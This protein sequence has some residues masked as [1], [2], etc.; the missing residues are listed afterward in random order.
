MSNKIVVS[1]PPVVEKPNLVDSQTFQRS[2]SSFVPLT[3]VLNPPVFMT[4]AWIMMRPMDHASLFGVFVFTLDAD[5]VALVRGDSFGEIDVVREQ[6]GVTR[7][8][9]ENHLLV[10]TADGVVRQVLFD[11]GTDLNEKIGLTIFERLEDRL[12][13]A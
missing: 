2:K 7:R 4:P 10:P 12:F 8:Q 6:Y 9:P 11:L 5:R 1:Q 13:A 3:F